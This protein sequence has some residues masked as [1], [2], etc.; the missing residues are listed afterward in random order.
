MTVYT[1]GVPLLVSVFNSKTQSDAPA[2]PMLLPA[3]QHVPPPLA[4]FLAA[5]PVRRHGR[6]SLEHAHRKN[7]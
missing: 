2:L 6:L 3:R 5:A 1:L 7:P 4:R